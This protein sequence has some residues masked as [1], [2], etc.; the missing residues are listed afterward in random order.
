MHKAITSLGIVLF[1]TVSAMA[2]SPVPVKLYLGGGVS[3]GDKPGLF[4]SKYDASPHGMVGVGVGVATN[5]EV[6]LQGTYDRF[7]NNLFGDKNGDIS[8]FSGSLFLKPHLQH[9]EFPVEFYALA[10]LGITRVN[11]ETIVLPEGV[12]RQTEA[13]AYSLAIEDQTKLS[14]SIGIGMQ[15]Q[16][17]SKVGL[18]GQAIMNEI[19]TEQIDTVFD[20]GMRT[21][22]IA[23]GLRLL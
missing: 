7:D 4:D 16:L 6:I 18:F 3:L 1:L 8:I 2:Q 15:Y 17:F 13:I 5:F 22:S 10:G 14:Y 23:F 19:L 20:N 9:P 11:M 12:D 21:F